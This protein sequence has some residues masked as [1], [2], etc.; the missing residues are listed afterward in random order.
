MKTRN[1]LAMAA[2]ATI[3]M[4]SCS[5]EENLAPV[6]NFPADGVIRITTNVDAPRTRAGF[7]TDNLL[8]FNLKITTK[9]GDGSVDNNYSYYAFMKKQDGGTWG[10]RKW[11][12]TDTPLTMLW[13]SSTQKITATA[14]REPSSA[15]SEGNFNDK[16]IVSVREDQSTEENATFS[17]YL[18][19]VPT[20][21]DPTAIPSQLVT[22]GKLKITLSHLLSKVNIT[23]T[24]AT[25]FNATG[26]PTANPVTLP[27]IG[28]TMKGK[29]F[30]PTTG[31][32]GAFDG[33]TATPIIPYHDAATGYTAPTTAADKAVVKYEAILIPQTVGASTFTVAFTIGGKLYEWKSTNGVTFE[34]GKQYALALTVGK[35]LITPSN[36]TSSEWT[37]GTGGSLETE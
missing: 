37:E 28:G 11:D 34:S 4:A 25:E 1:I 32:W 9:N 26:L 20:D 22:G 10:S 15:T 27:V 18:Y 3:A 30:T 36:I 24:L 23:L 13:K 29:L 12:D 8:G 35:D 17:D 5:Q 31:V 7:T 16:F 19:M 2:M 33:N 14:M 6:T 21:I